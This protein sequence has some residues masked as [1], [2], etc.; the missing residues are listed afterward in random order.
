MSKNARYSRDLKK[1]DKNV[2]NKVTERSIILILKTTMR[3]LLL[4]NVIQKNVMR[5]FHTKEYSINRVK[6]RQKT[7]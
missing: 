6:M 4:T 2:P 7:L 5:R 3:V 1:K